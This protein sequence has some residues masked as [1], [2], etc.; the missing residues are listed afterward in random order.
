LSIETTALTHEQRTAVEHPLDSPAVV[1]AGA[2][3]GKTHTII[4]RVAYLHE[5]GKIEAKNILLLT[6]ARKAAAELRRRVLDRLGPDIEPPHCSTFHAFAAGVLRE[7]AYE[8][9][10]SPDASVIEDIDARLEFRAAFDDIVHGNTVDASAFPLRTVQRAALRDA[11]FTIAQRLKEQE[12]PVDRFL[13]DA[14]AAADTIM[15]LPYREIRPRG[16]GSKPRKATAQTTDDELRAEADEARARATAAAAIFRRYDERLKS[17][18]ALTYADLLLLARRGIAENPR[19]AAEL[20]GRYRHCIVDEFQDTDLAQWR[21]LETLFGRELDR[22]TVVGDPRQ[23]IFGFR[24]ATPANVEQFG[25]LPRSRRYALTENR[26]SHQE[27]LDLAHA[28]ISAD[29][30]DPQPLRAHRGHAGAPVV[31]VASRWADGDNPAPDAE[32][33]RLAQARAVAQRVAAMLRHGRSPRDI[34]ILTRNKTLIAPFTEALAQARIPFRLLGGAGFYETAEIRDALA[35]LRLLANPLDG[36]AAARVCASQVCGLSDAAT[37]SLAAG[38]PPDETAFARRLLVEA[39]A[40]SLD[41]DSR[42]RIMRLRAII[43]SLEPYAAAPLTEAVGAV[44]AL[45]GFALTY[46]RAGDV[47]ALANLYKLSVLAAHFAAR[48]HGAQASD[49]VNYVEELERIEF[50]D[51]EAD[52]PATDAVTIMTIHAAKGL[53]WPVVFV[54][55]VWPP[56]K[57]APLVTLDENGALLCREGPDGSKPFHVESAEKMPDADGVFDERESGPIPEERRLFYVALTRAR[58]E[59]YVLGWRRYSA[60]NPA[61]RPHTFLEEAEGWLTRAGWP[62][63]ELIVDGGVDRGDGGAVPAAAFA[64]APFPT[65]TAARTHSPIQTVSRKLPP[66]SFSLLHAYERCPRSVTYR[67]IFGL[68]DVRADA[69]DGKDDTI[70]E[71][72]ELDS[73]EST[74]LLAAG[75]Y[76]RL[77]HRALELWARG[78]TPASRG[79]HY[80]D[81]AVREAAKDLQFKV[82]AKHLTR[83][84]AAFD[85]ATAALKGWRIENAEAPF[86]LE[87]GDVVVSGFIDLIA[88]DPQGRIVVIDYKTGTMP[89]S[90]HALQL[91]IYRDAVERVYGFTD[92]ACAIGRFAEDDTFSLET[93]ELPSHETVRARIAAVAEGLGRADV[94]AKPG[95]WCWTCAY[96]AAPCDAYPRG[97]TAQSG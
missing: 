92:V 36:H 60:T 40:D 6:F 66:L 52:S 87:Y 59:L 54:I 22:V 8:L 47:Q 83:A 39:V 48:N 23:S 94:T 65:R 53:E 37:T 56:N 15:Q 71:A 14:L 89:A 67:T 72:A 50:D 73:A 17:R 27:I 7:H 4:N 3:T 58:D 51:R 75:D 80:T 1:D 41:G 33:N 24:G 86:S 63:D 95:R 13:R 20:R 9:K 57:G 32:A 70:A 29:F 62:A 11:L 49:F 74:A 30:D 21:F 26:R 46:E 55:D 19:L 43:D 82:D 68:P 88:R 44:F 69:R 16:K 76:G 96:R 97:K 91:G 10:V 31:H 25:A 28:I 35:W 34:A 77:V 45:T 18:H 78:Q 84:S 79:R 2:G 81:D 5:S 61:G 85:S 12:I 90:D 42:E 38:L 64:A 93:V